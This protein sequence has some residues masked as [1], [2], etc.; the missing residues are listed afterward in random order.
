MNWY[1][2]KLTFQTR[3]YAFGG[4]LIGEHLEKPALPAGMVAE[5]WQIS[6]YRE[7]TGTV[8]NG[9]FAGVRFH[10]L[11]MT[12]PDQ[13]VGQGWRGPHFPL[14]QK[15]LDASHAL[16]VHLHPDDETARRMFHQP[17]GK[18]EAWHILWAAP[19]ASILAGIKPGTTRAELLAAFRRQEYETVMPRFPISAG[20]TV[21]VPG[22]VL[23][24][25]GPGTL[26]FEAQ[27]TSDI[28]LSV[29]PMDPYGQLLE[30]AAWEA[31]IQ[32]TLDALRTEYQPRPNPGLTRRQGR[33]QYRVG[34]ADRYFA[35]ERWSLAEPHQE[36]AH[37]RRCLC[38]S[39]VGPAIDLVYE[40]GSETLGR[41]ESCVL[42]A[43]MGEVQIVPRERADLVACYVPDLGLDIVQP[44]LAQGYEAQA[45]TALGAPYA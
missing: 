23:H 15:F 16:P 29:M 4:T 17:N 30:P 1:P 11:V 3:N 20:D 35:L 22:G 33:N 42:P 26:I 41:A 2:L 6:D 32:Q 8:I 10:D 25:F 44:L 45:I 34:A 14:L 9:A 18:T 38:L 31:N 21:Y 43:A 37:P 13:L 28:S 19:E 24:T 36:P 5:T 7:S 12:Y 27:Q 39:N 40:S